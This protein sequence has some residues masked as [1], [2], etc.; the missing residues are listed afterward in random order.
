MVG[1]RCKPRRFIRATGAHL[2]RIAG[3]VTFITKPARGDVQHKERFVE[4]RL[5]MA[6]LK[7]RAYRQRAPGYGAFGVPESCSAISLERNA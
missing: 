7:S 6:R 3:S 4:H 2:S 5:R 1:Y